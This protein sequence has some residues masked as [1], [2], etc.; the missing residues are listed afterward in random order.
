L[1]AAF[2]HGPCQWQGLAHVWAVAALK[3]ADISAAVC[4]IGEVDSKHICGGW[5]YSLCPPDYCRQGELYKKRNII[6]KD[7]IFP[8]STDNYLKISYENNFELYSTRLNILP[9]LYGINRA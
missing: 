4:L 2:L 3:K 9:F 1:G 8:I 7:D 5:L 6:A